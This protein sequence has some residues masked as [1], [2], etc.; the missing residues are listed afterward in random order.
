MGVSV[1]DQELLDLI[2]EIWESRVPFNKILGFIIDSL[3]AEQASV[4]LTMREDLIG[5][6]FKGSLHG[7]VI[8]ATLDA[9]GGLVAFLGVV[10]SMKDKSLREKLDRFS[11]MGTIDLRIDYLRPGLG[12]HF[13]AS[14]YILRLGNRVAVTRMELHNDGG[15]LTAVGTGAD[16]VA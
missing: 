1:E 11:R 16:L 7:G 2:R 9:T 10:E 15:T 5:N 8:A 6:Y 12:T 13:K 14:G 4:K 3:S